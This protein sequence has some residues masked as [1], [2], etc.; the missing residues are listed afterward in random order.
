MTVRGAGSNPVAR[1]RTLYHV[2]VCSRCGHVN[3]DEAR[4]CDACGSAL[5][6]E[7]WP[8]AERKLA[9]VLF[10]DLVGSTELGEQDPERTRAL[11]DRFYEAMAAE[12]AAAGGVIEKF[13]GDA[14]LAVFGVPTALEDHAER[15]L[16]AALAMLRRLEELFGDRLALRIGV[17]TG[18][19]VMALPR[20]GS[21]FVTGDAVNVA[22]RLEQAAAGG[23]V[24]VGERTATVARG[25][26]EFGGP[27]TVEAKGKRGGVPCRRLVRALTLARPRGVANLARAFVG[28]ERDLDFLVDAFDR[29]LHERQPHFVTIVGDAGVGKTRLVRELWQ[30]LGA[31]SPEPLRRTGRCLP[32]GRGVT[33]WPLGEILKEHLGILESD[34]PETVR[35]K[36]TGGEI[37]GLALG[38][39]VAGNLHPL[40]ARD[41][42]HEAWIEF[43]ADLAAERPTVV[44]IEDVHWADE[45]LLELVGR[46]ARDARGPL[47]SLATA[48]PELLERRWPWTEPNVSTL[49]LEPLSADDAGRMVDDLL[50]TELPAELRDVVVDRAEGNPLFVEELVA[51]LIDQGA[52][53]R[54]D[55]GWSVRRLPEGFA[56]PDSVQAILSARIDLLEPPEKAALQAA[57]V[58]GRIFWTGPIYELL[59]GREPDFRTLED[60]D[61]IRRRSGSSMAGEREY[62][63]KHA[64]TREVAYGT[65][66][67]ASR[68]R[69]HAAF[70]GWLE[71]IGEGRDEHASLLAH[72]YADA[73][74]PEDVD[75]AWPGNE[76]EAERLRERAVV[77]LQRAADLAVGRYEIDDAL[78]LLHR[79]LEL[80]ANES[81]QADLW[82]A[83]GRANALKY[84]GEAFWTAMEKAIELCPDSAAAAEMYSELALET[85]YRSGMWKRLPR[86]ELIDG[87]IERALELAERETVARAKALIAKAYRDHTQAHAAIEA[88]ELA[89]RLG[90]ADLRSRA[91]SALVSTKAAAGD[92]DDALAW[93]ERRFELLPEISDPDELAFV[94]VG[95]IPAY[96]ALGRFAEARR[97]ARR[98][99]E[100]AAS[101]TVHHRL[102]GVAN[103]IEVEV[104]TGNWH[105]IRDLTARAQEAVAANLATP[106]LWNTRSLLLCAV[107][108]QAAGDDEDAQRLG[109]RA[110]ALGMEGYGEIHDAPRLRLALLRGDLERAEQLVG[111]PVSPRGH[112][113]FFF[114]AVATRLDALAALDDQGTLECEAPPFLRPHTYLEPFALRALG[115]VRQDDGLVEKAATRFQEIGLDWHA[116]QTTAL[117]H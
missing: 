18:D 68:A 70:A 64:L 104:L 100:I 83:I 3:H 61:F 101:L 10:A 65:L 32:Y 62:A 24:L 47:L 48:R 13:A 17:N 90:D 53:A 25:A 95:A 9:T 14:V 56:V 4:F 16:H 66:P 44:L 42:L 102:H 73:V 2:I 76:H 55:G 52:L 116:A 34:P 86:R 78:A 71:R 69:L 29:V 31:R 30:L 46:I 33:Y 8:P 81:L 87:W 84:D 41:R 109:E 72:H 36:L 113:L 80:A 79:A 11:L 112:N 77:W 37:L 54:T 27:T 57:S 114:D 21:S 7:R 28:R 96:T 15:A 59:E 107:A 93:A 23:E 51:S 39:E 110:E 106:C 60:R 12:V 97:L 75:L 74:R 111:G 117:L 50:V 45:P 98:H 103:L 91:W 67:K 58:I 85:S 92:Y 49:K 40:A 35:R 82:W 26:F 22:A 19:V 38:L 43:L 6:G 115:I 99:D 5:G 88:A 94:H 108:A 63:F 105:A 20:E 89:Q 1:G